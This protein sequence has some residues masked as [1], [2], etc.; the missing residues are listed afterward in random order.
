MKHVSL[1]NL[2]PTKPNIIYLF[3]VLSYS[4]LLFQIKYYNKMD[5]EAGPSSIRKSRRL[6]GEPALHEDYY[7]ALTR[8]NPPDQLPTKASI[9]GRMRMLCVGGWGH[10]SHKAAVEVAKEVIS[11]YFHENFYCHSNSKIINDIDELYS[12]YKEGGRLA[13]AGR[14]TFKKA[15]EYEELIKN[16]DSLFDVATESSERKKQLEEEWGVKMGL[17]EKVYLKDQR[18]PRQMSCDSGV[19][20][21]FYRA[22]MVQQRKKE[23]DQPYRERREEE[24]HGKSIKQIGEYLRSM[25]E[26]PYSLESVTTPM[27]EVT[28]T[29]QPSD[30][31]VITMEDTVLVE[32]ESRKKERVC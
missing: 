6:L 1:E 12:I 17:R 27:K 9:I 24:F 11:K 29:Y 23:R 15:K 25:G 14:L 18:G 2:I 7:S 10:T 26:M 20:P 21:T 4:I 32:K 8:F 31:Q 13:R 30:T 3:N 19:D 22:F 28:S 16:R 5:A